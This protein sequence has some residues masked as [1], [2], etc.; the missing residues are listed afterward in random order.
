MGAQTPRRSCLICRKHE[1]RSNAGIC[2][3]CRPTPRIYVEGETIFIGGIGPMSHDTALR[4][5]HAIA[6]AVTP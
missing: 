2:W 6:D 1:T 5:A 4:L 3:R